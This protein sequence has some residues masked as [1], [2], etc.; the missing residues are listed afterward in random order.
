MIRDNLRRIHDRMEE[1]CRRVRRNPA[2]VTL[3]GVTKYSNVSQV[4]EV[5]DAGLKDIAENRVQDAEAKFPQLKGTFTKHLIGHLQ[6]N[7]VKLALPL[8]DLIHAVDSI[9]CADEIQKQAEKI[10]KTARILIQVNTSA[11]EQKSGITPQEVNSLAKHVAGLKNVKVEGLMTMG[12]LT[13]DRE[14]IRVCFKKLKQVFEELKKQFSD[15]ERVSMKY[16]SM[17][18]SGDYDIALEEGA[19]MIRIGRAIFQ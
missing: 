19:N 2:D 3:I 15:H 1:I 7:K 6:T 14:A 9:K 11:E 12:P 13:E 5:L 17:G 8:F 16:L 10:N 18:M 4:Q